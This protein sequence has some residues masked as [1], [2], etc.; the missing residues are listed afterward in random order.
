MDSMTGYA[1]AEFHM[2]Q[3]MSPS[4]AWQELKNCYMPKTLAATERLT[5]EFQAIHK[6]EGEDPL[7]F[8]GRVLKAADELAMLGCGERVQEVSRHI[9]T[10]LPSLYTIQRKSI[11]SRPSIPRSKINVIIRDAYVNENLEKDMVTKAL[12]VKVGV[13][14]HTLYAGAVQPAGGAGT[15]SGSQG[16]N[17]RGGRYKQQQQFQ[18]QQQQFRQQQQQQRFQQQQQQQHSHP[19]QNCWD[20]PGSNS[21]GTGVPGRGG[22]FLQLVGYVP[23]HRH[24]LCRRF[25]RRRWE[26]RR[27]GV[28]HRIQYHGGRRG[29]VTD[30]TGRVTM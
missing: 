5:K 30:A 26:I 4:G 18:Q 14:P 6:E 2:Q 10:N 11:L 15:G 8:L 19:K 13:D 12:R 16:R 29:Y 1:I 24:G 22:R 27:D 20:N 9:V 25:P 23:I 7:V 17:T 28:P 21:F 3:S